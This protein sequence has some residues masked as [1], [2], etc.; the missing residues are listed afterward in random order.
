MENKFIG[1]MVGLTVGVLMISG[2][3]WPIVSD[4]T[5]INKTFSNAGYYEMTYDERENVTV[6]WNYETPYQITVNDE[7]VALN[8]TDF[9]SSQRKTILI[10]DDF[11]LRTNRG[12]GQPIVQF[13]TPTRNIFGGTGVNLTVTCESGTYTA[14][15][16]PDTVSGTYTTLYTPSNN[17]EYVMKL[18][19]QDAYLLGNTEFIAMGTSYI[20][21]E[22]TN[23]GIKITG[24]IDNGAEIAAWFGGDWTF[25]NV[26]V[27]SESV[28]GYRDLYTISTITADAELESVTGSIT[29]SYF[30][31]P[32]EITAE[33]SEHLDTMQIALIGAIGTLGAI[34]LIAAAAGAIR[35]LD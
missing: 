34:V 10:G 9:S 5:T 3:L 8:P 7:T 2:F 22:N 32:T 33:K 23:V 25:N 13:T 6:V 28:D 4:A 15:A 30:L 24:S 31:V 19:D 12:S 20:G 35:R 17:G 11:V 1:L 27:N 21:P 16:G 29:Y 14:T 18:S 26:Q